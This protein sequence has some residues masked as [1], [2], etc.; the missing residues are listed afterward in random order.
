MRLS[1]ESK[2][3]DTTTGH[4][5]ICGIV[6]DKPF[7]TYPN[8]FPDDF[9]R[10]FEKRIGVET[11]GNEA[12]SGTEIIERL[13]SEHIATG[14]PII[15]TSADSVLQLA[16]HEDVIPLER[17]YD[18]CLAAREMSQVGRVI[19][20]PFT[21]T[22]PDYVR[23]AGRHDYSL[24]PPK[25]TMLDVLKEHG[26]EVVAIGKIHDIFGGCGTT[27]CQRTLDNEDGIRKT[28]RAGP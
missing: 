4:W 28:L 9:I 1:E 6:L 27:V 26:K 16:A 11:L 20:R 24:R 14:E 25:A 19:A 8:G 12:A 23:T 7:P 22:Y 21:G 18:M 15:Y 2:G 17:L 13:G 10:E 5:E 3:K